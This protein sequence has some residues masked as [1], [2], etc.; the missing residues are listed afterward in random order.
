ME[1]VVVYM[2]TRV[3]AVALAC[4]DQDLTAHDYAYHCHQVIMADAAK[5][6]VQ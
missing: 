6:V 1:T 4:P 5:L 3:A 2:A